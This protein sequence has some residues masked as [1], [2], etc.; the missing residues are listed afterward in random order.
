[1]GDQGFQPATEAVPTAAPPDTLPGRV[2]PEPPELAEA[3]AMLKPDTLLGQGAA[4]PSVA[5]GDPGSD[6]R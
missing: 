4:A 3:I 5:P 1:M 2:R 6:E